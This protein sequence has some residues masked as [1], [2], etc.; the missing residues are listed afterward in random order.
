MRSIFI[1]DGP[2]SVIDLTGRIAER[3]AVAFA[4]SLRDDIEKNIFSF[5]SLDGDESKNVK[6]LQGAAKRDEIVGR[7]YLSKPDFEFGNFSTD[8]LVDSLITLGVES[9]EL[10]EL[11]ED[12]RRSLEENLRDRAAECTGM[13]Q[14][15]KML[16]DVRDGLR[17]VLKTARWGE[18]LAK[19]A[20]AEPSLPGSDAERPF[21]DAVKRASWSATSEYA[22]ARDN[23]R[24]DPD[25]LRTIPREG[26]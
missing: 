8:E 21:F 6:V 4:Q 25:T 22:L 9:G 23:W 26:A 13:P 20:M 5:V 19:V 15:G 18:L 2:I 7:V 14:F 24:I 11:P 12:E 17:S 3:G 16:S 1:N 10:S